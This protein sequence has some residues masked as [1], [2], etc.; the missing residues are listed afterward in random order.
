VTLFQE[1]VRDTLDDLYRSEPFGS[2]DLQ[3]I[4]NFLEFMRSSIP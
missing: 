3:E 1:R 4:L 2:N